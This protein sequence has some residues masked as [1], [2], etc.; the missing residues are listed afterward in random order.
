MS[1]CSTDNRLIMDLSKGSFKLFTLAVVL[2]F[3]HIIYDLDVKRLT[4]LSRTHESSCCYIIY[5]IDYFTRS[6]CNWNSGFCCDEKSKKKYIIKC[7]INVLV[8]PLPHLHNHGQPLSLHCL[9]H[10]VFISR[11]WVDEIPM[12]HNI[13]VDAC[14]S[15]FEIS[16]VCVPPLSLR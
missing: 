15:L 11:I 2:F 4:H 3:M 8:S 6:S 1:H 5:V 16:S 13:C 7:C 14:H 9:N 12:N 10:F